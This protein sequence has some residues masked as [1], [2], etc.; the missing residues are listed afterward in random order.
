MSLRARLL[1]AVATITIV[2]LGISS[3]AT[4]SFLESYLYGRVDQS[5]HFATR[6]ISG[7]VDHGEALSSCQRRE[8][9]PLPPPGS[10]H[11][12]GIPDLGSVESVFFEVRSASGKV[13][14]GE[15]CDAYVQG[16][17]Y[18]AAI[19]TSIAGLR[20]SSPVVFTVSAVEPG[21]PPFR[22]H[23]S[24]LSDG[25]TLFVG[26]PLNDTVNTLH[27]LLLIELAV[28]ALALFI[29][30]LGGFF[31]VRVGLRPLDAVEST[32][33]SIMD[34]NLSDRVPGASRSTEIGRLSMTLNKMLDRIEDSFRA[35]EMV[36]VEL[37]KRDELL[38]R[39][40]SDASHELRTPIAAIAAYAELIDHWG[41]QDPEQASRVLAGIRIQAQRM[42]QLVND[43]L[44]LARMDEGA[45]AEQLR[46]ELVASCTEVIATATTVSP[47]W[48][49]T[50]EAT[51]SLEIIGNPTQLRRIVE[52]LLANV[53]AHTPEGTSTRVAVTRDGGDAVI[54]VSDDGPG[55]SEETMAHALDRF[56]RGD[57]GRD[58]A[59]TGSGLGLSIV[60]AM[61]HANTGG[62]E[63]SRRMPSG[64]IVTLRFPL[65]PDLRA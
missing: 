54:S 62:V 65:A 34:G 53:R 28:S 17:A 43:L 27:N 5:L 20:K 57:P 46:V 42:E 45:P 33:E 61:V 25:S 40:V 2:A 39:F 24:I 11:H 59:Q 13:A 3:V 38:H 6:A 8:A 44:T 19:P 9:P 48:P 51:E 14:S 7:A 16:K 1:V 31:F 60:A 50:F 52:N 10:S 56:Y 21:G 41:A 63:V 15:Q 23:A 29:A 26:A 4:Y 55:M 49:V 36:E 58:R 35:R 37:R 22:V 12:R 47:Q 18:E 30:I 32:A 64:T